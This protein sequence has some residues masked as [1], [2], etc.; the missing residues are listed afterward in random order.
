MGIE[1][2]STVVEQIQIYFRQKKKQRYNGCR[3]GTGKTGDFRVMLAF[4]LGK[5]N[6]SSRTVGEGM[7]WRIFFLFVFLLISSAVLG[8]CCFLVCFV[9]S[10][11]AVF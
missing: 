1:I 3:E 11:F 9:G 5:K 8:L 4:Q 2:R 6:S 7:T 10:V